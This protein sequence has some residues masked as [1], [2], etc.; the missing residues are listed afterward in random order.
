MDL[1]ASISRV[2]PQALDEY[3]PELQALDPEIH[4]TKS[5]S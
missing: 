5:F 1:A 4:V 2:L 3:Q